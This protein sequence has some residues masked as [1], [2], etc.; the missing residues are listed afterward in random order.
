MSLQTLAIAA[1][2]STSPPTE[3]AQGSAAG[4]ALLPNASFE[5]TTEAGEPS[6]WRVFRWNGEGAAICA[7]FGRSGSRCAALSSESGAD[8]SWGAIVP[9]ISY[10]RYRFSGWIKTEDLVATTGR[11]ALFNLHGMRDAASPVL[12]GTHDWT[13]LSYEFDTGATDAI[14]LNCLFGGWGS[15]TGKAWYDDL[16][17]ELLSSRELSPT[18]TIDASVERE[19]IHPFVYGQFIE[20]L[21]RCIYGGIWAEMLEDRK[22]F[23]APGEEGS[24]WSVMVVEGSMTMDRES[25]YVGEQT[26]VLRASSASRVRLSHGGL[27]LVAGARYEGYMVVAGDPSA[28]R[29]G[30]VLVWGENVGEQETVVIDSLSADFQRVPIAFTAGA[31]TDSGRLEILVGGAGEVRIGTLSLM[32]A[33]NV[34]GFRAD[35]LA[36][37]RELDSPIYRWP[38]GNFVSGYDWRDGIGERD[39]R[40]PRKNPAWTGVEHNDVGLHEFLRLCELIEAEPYVTV[41]TGL[42]GVEMSAAEVEYCNGAADTP[43]GALRA[44]NGH[45]EPFAVTW[46]AIGNEMY[47][48]WQLGHMPLEE[49]VEKHNRVVDAMRAVDPSIRVVAVGAV[50]RWD[51]LMLER[52]ADHMDLIS[53]HFYCQERPGLLGHAAWPAEHVKRIADAHRRYR[54]E[55]GALAGRDVRI[56]LDEYNYWYGPHLFGELGTRYFLKDALG[57]A[58]GLHEIFRNSDLYFMANYAQ[59]V[60]VIGAIKAS[61]TDSAFA[62]TGLVLKLYRERYGSIPVEVSGAPE[63]LDVAAALNEE[64]TRLIVAVVN[65]TSQE[66]S[67]DLKITGIDLAGEGTRWLLTGPHARAYNAPGGP[68]EVS[69]LETPTGELAGPLRVPP[70]SVSLH[71]L[72]TRR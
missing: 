33:D 25:P 51:E 52:C 68:T 59:T 67:L 46:W 37:L 22:F 49:Y 4:D 20:H 16:R 65:P 50:G 3:P 47:G 15:A 72:V 5:E 61:K 40:P 9:V 26:P 45:P 55:I 56:A 18:V 44:R 24:P 12:A 57:I 71:A 69:I 54:S 36:L 1:L 41:N 23:L 21:G 17:L 13:E 7:D 32:P 60:N 35:V 27:G 34:E 28:A 29:V 11:G 62:T 30:V 42:G 70:M 2:L 6:G 14:H 53:E 19:P 64:R 10:S 38:G 58:R 63:P 48:G 66:I 39:R 43:K 8:I 31:S